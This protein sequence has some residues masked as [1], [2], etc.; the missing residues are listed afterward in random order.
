MACLLS[1]G[2]V[3]ALSIL[4]YLSGWARVTVGQLFL[5]YD[6]FISFV[7]DPKRSEQA[8]WYNQ[9]SGPD[10]LE[11]FLHFL[12]YSSDLLDLLNSRVGMIPVTAD[13][14]IELEDLR[15]TVSQSFSLPNIV[16]HWACLERVLKLRF[17]FRCLAHTS[18]N[19]HPWGFKRFLHTL[20]D[21]SVLIDSM[22]RRTKHLFELDK[23]NSPNIVRVEPAGPLD[24][25]FI[26]KCEGLAEPWV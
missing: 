22:M 8:T 24:K 19:I 10:G 7:K 3:T 6:R 13:A 12:S 11:V 25:Q 2:T 15:C 23:C 14:Y 20:H 4:S 9:K 17:D 5:S 26:D 1:V 16:S 21:V 18:D